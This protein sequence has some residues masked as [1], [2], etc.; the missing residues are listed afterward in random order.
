MNLDNRETEVR[1]GAKARRVFTAK[2]WN[3]AVR[4]AG[5]TAGNMW[6]AVFGPLR[7]NA[8][9]ATGILRYR[10]GD[11]K[12]AR[13]ARG[14]APFFSSGDFLAG[15]NS[16]AR[17]VAKAKKG[18]ARFWIVIPGGRLNF[19]PHKIEAFRTLPP[20]ERVA[21][22]REYR[23]ALIMALQEGRAVAAAKQAAKAQAKITARA[24]RQAAVSANRNARRAR[25]IPR[26]AA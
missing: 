24:A 5:I 14:E 4:A 19:H 23:R 11:A 3:D 10:P 7:W 22:A 9:Y 12:R 20:R 21:V 8:N 25:A 13:M 2:G 18:G 26:N 16:R 6:I 17:T 15:F 1:L